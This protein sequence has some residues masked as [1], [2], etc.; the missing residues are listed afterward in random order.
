MTRTPGEFLEQYIRELIA[1]EVQRHL[2]GNAELDAPD[3]E[4]ERANAGAG[5]SASPPEVLTASEAADL[6][7]CDR[8]SVYEAAGRHEIPH[9]RLGR[10]VIF[11][12][13]ALLDWL[14]CKGPSER[15]PS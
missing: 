5:D 6:L 1:E 2:T 8:K 4:V 11:S 12:R 9:Q 14:G 7:G 10:R 15:N 3:T 13:K